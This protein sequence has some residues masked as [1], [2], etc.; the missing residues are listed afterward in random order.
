MQCISSQPVKVLMIIIITIMT[1]TGMNGK[2]YGICKMQ[3]S[4]SS[5]MSS[6]AME[7]NTNMVMQDG[8]PCDEMM[9]QSKTDDKCCCVNGECSCVS[10]HHF[11]IQIKVDP[12]RTIWSISSVYHVEKIQITEAYVPLSFIPPIA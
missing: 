2:L 12:I 10:F 4:S 1:S 11:V 7:S 5:S 6:T 9:A 8:M 3:M